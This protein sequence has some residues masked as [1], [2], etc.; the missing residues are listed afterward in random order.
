MP[1]FLL[2]ILSFFM[3][4]AVNAQKLELSNDTT[5]I[6]FG[7]QFISTLKVDIDADKKKGDLSIPD[8]LAD[9]FPNL[10]FISLQLDTVSEEKDKGFSLSYL[11]HFKLTSFD[12]GRFQLG[13]I[14]VTHAGDTLYSNSTFI[15][16]YPVA[17][18]TSSQVKDIKAN[19]ELP[20]TL[21]DYVVAYWPYPSILIALLLIGYVVWRYLKARKN[22]PAT[23][24]AAPPA[25]PIPAHIEARKALEKLK[26]EKAWERLTV[27]E[28]Y[29]E[30]TFITRRYLGRRFEINALE[31]TS[32]ELS[33]MLNYKL[34]SGTLKNDLN[35]I[36]N[37]ADMV[38][39][40]K[41]IPDSH[42]AIESLE[43]ALKI[44]EKT[45]AIEDESNE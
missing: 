25:P 11:F 14:P 27:K 6:R 33:A 29:S 15:D 41:E 17:V 7:E 37:L 40:A 18:D 4:I 3:V 24:V 44:I 31:Q 35:E 36:L 30:I 22:K 26:S 19:L 8:S 45:T 12:S 32:S 2:C 1:R 9:F 28:Y 13:P 34:T 23:T 39:F 42:F 43:K 10:E 5:Q 38:K 20:L 16:V 21:K